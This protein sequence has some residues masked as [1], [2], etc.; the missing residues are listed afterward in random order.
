MKSTLGHYGVAV[1]EVRRQVRAVARAHRDLSADD[2]VALARTLWSEPVHECRL[3]AALMLAAYVDHLRPA[4]VDVIEEFLRDCGTW[5]LVDPL[6]TAVAGPL[7]LRF[8]SLESTYR[9]WSAD[10][11][12]WVRRSGVLAFLTALRGE[13][14]FDNHFPVFAEI[15]D[16]L[17]DD[18]RFFIRKS[19]GWVLRE[20]C[21]KRPEAVY[22]WIAPRAARLSGVTMREA[23]RYLPAEQRAY[24]TS[25]PKRARKSHGRTA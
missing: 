1:P 19:I 12:Q 7:L 14:T 8:P 20:A 4:D 3:A 18:P 10:E 13:D 17:L 2:V 15:A 23:V 5:A 11:H 22:D 9:Q 24:L 16:P 21:K 25:S 6:A